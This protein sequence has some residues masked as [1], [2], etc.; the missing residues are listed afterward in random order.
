MFG[1]GRDVFSGAKLGAITIIAPNTVQEYWINNQSTGGDL[2]L[3]TNGQATPVSIGEDVTLICSCDQ[4]NVI[5]A[6]TGSTVAFPITISQGGT[7]ALDIANAQTNLEV[8]TNSKRPS[9]HPKYPDTF[10]G[11]SFLVADVKI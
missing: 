6:A 10:P 11:N 7:N 5:N 2:T 1:S 9:Y 3:G 8:P 4:I